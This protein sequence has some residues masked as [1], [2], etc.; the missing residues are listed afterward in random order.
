MLPENSKILLTDTSSEISATKTYKINDGKITGYI[1]GKEALMQSVETCLRTPRHGYAIYSYDYGN[2][3]ESLM[4]L[5][6]EL[7]KARIEDRLKEA[8]L[9]DERITA[10]TDVTASVMDRN[11]YL[12]FEIKTIYGDDYYEGV[13]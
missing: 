7:L 12:S 4:S 8:L 3:I 11:L 6:E 10:V 9:M 2:E 13:I 1:D 5:G